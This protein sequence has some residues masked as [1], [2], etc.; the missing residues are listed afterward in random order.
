MSEKSKPKV[1]D[2]VMVFRRYGDEVAIEQHTVSKVGR[3]YFSITE[4]YWGRPITFCLQSRKVTSRYRCDLFAFNSE[5]DW[6]VF[7]QTEADEKEL[8]MLR[9]EMEK[10]FR[11]QRF[12]L[13]LDQ[14]RRIQAI[15]QERPLARLQT[16]PLTTPERCAK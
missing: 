1:G 13:S 7:L 2:K 8:R 3:K 16:R 15:V 11:F 12:D 10:I 6:K 14:L 9:D 4:E 5:D